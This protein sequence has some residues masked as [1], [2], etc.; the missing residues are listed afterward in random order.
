MPRTGLWSYKSIGTSGRRSQ[1]GMAYLAIMFAI[2]LIV[3]ATSAASVVWQIETRRSKEKVL[4]FEGQEFGRALATYQLRHGSSPTPN[5]KKLEELLHD[6]TGLIVNRDLRQIYVDPMTA[7]KDWGTVRLPD[8][9][10]VGVYSRSIQAPIQKSNFP[11]GLEGFTAAKRYS[12]WIF[13]AALP[14]AQEMDKDSSAAPT[15]PTA[16]PNLRGRFAR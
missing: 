10:I 9:Q 3:L 15:A 1:A 16:A 14:V 6:G 8:G 5:P 2:F 12:D 4:L 7:S 13:K 11:R